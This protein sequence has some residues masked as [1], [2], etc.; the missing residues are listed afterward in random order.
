MQSDTFFNNLQEFNNK[1][2]EALNLLN[3][4]K[5]DQSASQFIDMMGIKNAY[6]DAVTNFANNPAK[7][8]EHNL[9]YAS[10]ISGLMFH[11][12]EKISGHEMDNLYEPD[13]RDKRFKQKAWQDSMYFNFVK[14]FYLMSSD[15]HRSMLKKL[16]VSESQKKLLE[17]YTE[18]VLNAASPTNFL[19]LN[20][21]ALN[22]LVAT[23]G[24]NLIQ[25]IENFLNDIKNS[26]DVLSITTATSKIFEVGR[27]IASTEGKIIMENDLMQLI[28]YKPQKKVYQV[29][30]FVVP[31]WINKY[32]ILDLG[33][34]N[35]FIKYLVDLGF[36]VYLVS[37][38]NPG[39]K[40]AHK[41]FE[42][43]LKEGIDEPLEFLKKKFGYDKLNI[44]GY[45]IGGTLASCAAS[46]YAA[47]K[48]NHFSTLTL[49]TTMLDFSEPGDLGLFLNQDTLDLLKSEIKKKGYFSGKHMSYAFSLLRAN[50]LIWSFVVNNYLLG[51]KPMAFDLL[52]WNADNTNLPGSMHLFY[53]ENMYGSNN[54]VKKG[55][56][57]LLDTKI[58]LG[59][60]EVPAFFISAIEDHIAPWKS[61][62]K[63]CK[64]FSQKAKE[65]PVFCLAGS[66][67]IA[68]IINP[69][70]S[71][72]YNYYLNDK[73]YEDPEDWLNSSTQ[74]MG[75][76][77]EA[78]AE[79]VITRSGH[80]VSSIDYENLDFLQKAPG[81]YVCKKITK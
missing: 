5:F 2:I 70:A 62:Y 80:M 42:N 26:E 15:W 33:K 51:R 43:Y 72:K 45:C 29:P 9:E 60:I 74:Y 30:I 57:T 53:I 10:K 12:M 1:Y 66:G 50:E 75:S 11:F 68:G 58:D 55:G 54:L 48:K 14:Q 34:E 38:V 46:Y 47:K 21:E 31:P 27:N 61:T 71:R 64:L 8:F 76:W 28:C 22:E 17:F 35:S 39:P 73:I 67:H 59:K 63:G 69:P 7:F 78:W 20:P 25:G 77:W 81:S 44:I 13:A 65:K 37:W 19:N 40:L 32:Y 56:I 23:N 16:D 24:Q 41:S 3:K 36:Q 79:W 6:I 49:F 52:Y 4:K 18:Q